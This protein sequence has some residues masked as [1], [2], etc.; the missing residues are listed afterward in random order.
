M[1]KSNIERFS[2]DWIAHIRSAPGTDMW[3]NSEWVVGASIEWAAKRPDILRHAIIEIAKQDLTESEFEK[4]GCGPLENLMVHDYEESSEAIWKHAKI[5]GNLRAALCFV[6][7]APQH[8]A[9]FELRLRR[10]GFH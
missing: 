10:L 5:S 6:S 1:D 8:R 4:L 7:P 3:L 2:K 9:D